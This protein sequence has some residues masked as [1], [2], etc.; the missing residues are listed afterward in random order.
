VDEHNP[1]T[2]WVVPAVSDAM[3]MAIGGAMCVCRTEDGGQTW[4]DFR[5]GLPQQNCYDVVFRHALD[6]SGDRLAFGTTTG[7][8]FVSEDR[9]ESWQAIGHYFPP[10]YSVRFIT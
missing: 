8:V 3:R 4:A 9:G 2:A 10:V 7:N 1:D 5:V 6:I